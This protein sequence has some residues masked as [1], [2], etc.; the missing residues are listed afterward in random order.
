MVYAYPTNTTFS[1][2]KDSIKNKR[3]RTKESES[4]K[5]FCS[6]HSISI[7]KDKNT[8]EYKAVIKKNE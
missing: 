5:R 7:I 3:R 6:T 8:G 4:I 1:I 2:S